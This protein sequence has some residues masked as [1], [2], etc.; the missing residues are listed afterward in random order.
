[1]ETFEIDLNRDG[2]GSL[3]AKVEGDE[4]SARYCRPVVGPPSTTFVWQVDM[5][6]HA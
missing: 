5:W 3:P 2:G 4:I 1:M 6:V